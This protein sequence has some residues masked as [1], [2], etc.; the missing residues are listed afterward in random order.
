MLSIGAKN[1]VSFCIGIAA[2][3]SD[4]SGT[5]GTD[6]RR[7]REIGVFGRLERT[8]TGTG[9]LEAAP[10]TAL[11]ASGRLPPAADAACASLIIPKERSTS[12]ST[13]FTISVGGRA[14][15]TPLAAFSS[16]RSRIVLLVVSVEFKIGNGADTEAGLSVVPVTT[17]NPLMQSAIDWMSCTNL[18]NSSSCFSADGGE[19]SL[20]GAEDD[21][22]IAVSLGRSGSA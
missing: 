17:K 16:L 15:P 21:E 18:L 9:A 11:E 2:A 3:T 13:M 19:L 5:V 14:G 12:F 1:G 22:G 4:R 7:I 6:W 10:P 8:D 20:S